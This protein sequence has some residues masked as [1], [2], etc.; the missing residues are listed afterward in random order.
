MKQNEAQSLRMAQDKIDFWERLPNKVGQ[1]QESDYFIATE[2]VNG[3]IGGDRRGY[4][5]LQ[6]QS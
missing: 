3:H 4:E 5:H 6:F 1:V 2:V